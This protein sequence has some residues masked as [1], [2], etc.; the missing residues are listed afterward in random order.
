M[1]LADPPTRLFPAR[2]KGYFKAPA[3]SRVNT[4][5]CLGWLRTRGEFFVQ[6]K[7]PIS[8]N[9]FNGLAVLAHAFT[10]K[11][12]SMC[13]PTLSVVFDAKGAIRSTSSVLIK[14]RR[15]IWAH[16]VPLA[17]SVH[18][19]AQQMYG[20]PRYSIAAW[21][22]LHDFVFNVPPA[23]ANSRKQLLMKFTG[24][25]RDHLFHTAVAQSLWNVAR[26]KNQPWGRGA[27]RTRLYSKVPTHEKV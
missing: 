17:R 27:S 15:Y 23:L 22:P 7:C 20:N 21:K 9:P 26:G 19:M 25:N 8:G 13:E 12:C 11:Y 18:D 24:K 6:W 14:L 5:H 1:A 2:L 10:I 4:L 16:R 3:L